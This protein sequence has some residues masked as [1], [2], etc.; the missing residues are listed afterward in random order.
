MSD[1]SYPSLKP[2]VA[3]P[4]KAAMVRVSW[5]TEL[6]EFWVRDIPIDVFREAL[7]LKPDE[8]IDPAE[9]VGHKAEH[10]DDMHS[11]L[12]D[13]EDGADCC[14]DTNEREFEEIRLLDR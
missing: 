9:I 1:P 5:R 7:G 8:P 3:A 10:W 4:V 11:F 13:F 6:V 14:V 12:G 2:A